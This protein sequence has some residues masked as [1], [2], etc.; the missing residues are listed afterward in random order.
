MNEILKVG[1]WLRFGAGTCF[2]ESKE[3]IGLFVA[4]SDELAVCVA[5]NATSN[6]NGVTEF[7]R[8][9]RISPATTVVVIEPD[10]PEAGYHFS[11]QTAFDCNRPSIVG[12][13]QVRE[14]VRRGMVALADYNI[15][16]DEGL[17]GR[18]REGIL[19]S[20]LVEGKYKR[21]LEDLR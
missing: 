6:V 13:D 11:R 16:V 1:Q 9:R 19:S 15:E 8:R 18:I 4:V 17:L 14:W 2:G 20:P 7:A 21:I 3:H 10:E 5:V 12:Q